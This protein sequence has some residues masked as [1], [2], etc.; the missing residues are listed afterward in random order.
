MADV[1]C[2]IRGGPGSYQTRLS[3][4]QHAADRGATVHF[5]SIVDP[6]AYEPLHE[7]EQDAIRAEMAWRDLAM[8]RATAAHADLD[9]V[10]F[11]VAVRVGALADTI[12]AYAREVAA[13]S[14]LIGSPRPAADAVLAGG[15]E[16]FAVELRQKSGV[17]VVVVAPA[18]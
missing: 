4:L 10:R 13:G 6:V 7:G 2:A 16:Q 11:T 18:E 5:V 17:A 9:E 1:V 3:A 15:V 14:I 8:T 12:A